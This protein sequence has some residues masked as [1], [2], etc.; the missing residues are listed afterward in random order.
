MIGVIRQYIVLPLM[1]WAFAEAIFVYGA[2]SLEMIYNTTAVLLLIVL[3]KASFAIFLD[4]AVKHDVREFGLIRLTTVDK[5]ILSLS[6]F[7]YI[8]AIP[9]VL[10]AKVASY[11]YLN[12]ENF[13]NK[14]VKYG[15]KYPYGLEITF[16]PFLFA[17]VLEAM[18][19]LGANRRLWALPGIIIR[20]VGGWL[21]LQFYLYLLWDYYYKTPEL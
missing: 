5:I 6:K 14:F 10:I 21:L 3:N 12:P 16:Y 1:I 20:V 4:D 17:P 13:S 7:A 11:D 15:F 9:A 2:G 19:D 8:L 18:W